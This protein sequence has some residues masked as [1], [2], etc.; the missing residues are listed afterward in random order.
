MGTETYPNKRAPR[1]AS[2]AP[3]SLKAGYNQTG[4]SSMYDKDGQTSMK[5]HNAKGQSKEYYKR[6][7]DPC[8]SL[9][10]APDAFERAYNNKYRK[11]SLPSQSSDM[12]Y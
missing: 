7:Y 4:S 8:P 2:Y 12:G 6:M 3:G 9:G 10:G 11:T 1:E 5:D